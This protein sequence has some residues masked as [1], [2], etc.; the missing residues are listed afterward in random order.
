MFIQI[1]QSTCF[2]YVQ[3][4]INYQPSN[5]ST[6]QYVHHP[7]VHAL[8]KR[9]SKVTRHRSRKAVWELTTL[10][11]ILIAPIRS[12]NYRIGCRGEMSAP[13]DQ[14]YKRMKHVHNRLECWCGSTSD[15][16]GIFKHKVSSV[17]NL[18]HAPTSFHDTSA[19]L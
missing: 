11:G 3:F 15:V 7:T 4:P 19:A 16:I 6:N 14:T 5:Q 2:A 13:Q 18:A 17:P 10:T 1:K 9:S 8:I 12:E